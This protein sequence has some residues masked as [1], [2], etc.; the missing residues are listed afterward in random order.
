MGG[1]VGRN[2]NLVLEFLGRTK[3]IALITLSLFITPTRERDC[4]CSVTIDD[5]QRTEGIAPQES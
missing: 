1:R 4:Q 3:Q 2:N 5:M